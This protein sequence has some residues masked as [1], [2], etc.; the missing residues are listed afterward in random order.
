MLDILQHLTPDPPKFPVLAVVLSV[1]SGLLVL[2]RALYLPLPVVFSLN[3]ANGRVRGE[4]FAFLPSAFCVLI[5]SGVTFFSH[6][7]GRPG[8]A[9]SWAEHS[10]LSSVDVSLLFCNQSKACGCAQVRELSSATC[11]MDA[12]REPLTEARL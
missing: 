11:H 9:H 1:L 8:L 2:L 12:R 4:R 5:C 6:H 10:A 3:L 7:L